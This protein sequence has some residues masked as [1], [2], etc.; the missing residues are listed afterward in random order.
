MTPAITAPP[1]LATESMAG[2]VRKTLRR[3]LLTQG[4][5]VAM[6]ALFWLLAPPSAF[7]DSWLYSAAIGLC[8]WLMIDVGRQ[9]IG[10]GLRRGGASPALLQAWRGTGSLVLCVIIGTLLGYTFGSAIGDA[11]TGF[12]TPNLMA[13]RPALAISFIA[14]TAAVYYFNTTDRIARERAEAESARRAA[15][16]NQLKLLESQLEPHMLFNTLANL[17]VLIG[18][19]APRAQAMLDHLI[20][21]LRATLNASRTAMHPLSAECDRLA[22]YLALM[23]I[24]MGPRLSYRIELPADLRSQP[25]PTLLLQPLVENSIKHGLEP[26]VDGGSIGVKVA[27]DGPSLWI[28]VSDTGIGLRDTAAVSDHIDVDP[29]NS[30]DGSSGFGTRQ[31]RERLSAVYGDA[32]SLDLRNAEQAGAIATLRLPLSK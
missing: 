9:L 23:S 12:T 31:V 5:C 13:N 22:D 17:R 10:A 18:L 28:Q 26:K 30:L 11:I 7:F 6:G 19:D 4:L 20:A 25:V 32:A 3:G 1:D 15:A 8:C 24:R 29:G 2:R 27:R 21:F 14:A 16:E